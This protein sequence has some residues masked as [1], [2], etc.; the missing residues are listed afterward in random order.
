MACGWEGPGAPWPD[1]AKQRSPSLGSSIAP[2]VSPGLCPSVLSPESKHS[3]WRERQGRG[4]QTAPSK[5]CVPDGG[6]GTGLRGSSGPRSSCLSATPVCDE[7]E[8]PGQSE[9]A[10]LPGS[11]PPP[12]TAATA[13][14]KTTFK[15]CAGDNG[16]SAYFTWCLPWFEY[17]KAL[18]C[19]IQHFPAQFE[20]VIQFGIRGR[21]G[22]PGVGVI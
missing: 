21:L 1:G 11:A 8:R 6:S 10:H 18:S 2:G 16:Y 17:V 4:A 3:T 9:A 14:T 12:P 5:G 20:G 19:L 7:R 15:E 22:R 13:K